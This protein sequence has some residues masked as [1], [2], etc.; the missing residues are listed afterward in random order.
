[1]GAHERLIATRGAGSSGAPVITGTVKVGSNRCPR[2]HK[3]CG[4]PLRTTIPLPAHSSYLTRLTPRMRPR[5]FTVKRMEP[6][7]LTMRARRSARYVSR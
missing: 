2:P 3:L 6:E 4:F 7:V 1:V 5:P